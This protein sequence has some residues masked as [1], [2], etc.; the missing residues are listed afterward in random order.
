MI[1]YGLKWDSGSVSWNITNFTKRMGEPQSAI[2]STFDPLGLG[3]L[4]GT[5]KPK[6]GHVASIWTAHD[7]LH[8]FED[9]ES[10]DQLHY[11]DLQEGQRIKICHEVEDR[12]MEEDDGKVYLC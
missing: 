3:T 6:A 2:T 10:G 9:E 5:I 11:S 1:S 12:Y 7:G 8:I 4:W